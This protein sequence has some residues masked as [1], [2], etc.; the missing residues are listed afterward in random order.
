MLFEPLVHSLYHGTLFLLEMVVSVYDDLVKIVNVDAG[1]MPSG[2][3]LN[4]SIGVFLSQL[5]LEL[6]EISFFG[7]TSSLR[8]FSQRACVILEE[9]AASLHDLDSLAFRVGLARGLLHLV[10]LNEV[11]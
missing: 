7:N 8:Y 3:R 9:Q 1:T 2:V 10:D 6:D 11:D 4:F 5:V